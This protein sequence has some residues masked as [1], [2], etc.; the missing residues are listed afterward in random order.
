MN[1]VDIGNKVF[2][3]LVAAHGENPAERIA[4]FQCIMS[5]QPWFLPSWTKDNPD[6]RLSISNEGIW[7]G[8]EDAVIDELNL[9]IRA[10]GQDKLEKE[11][12]DYI[13]KERVERE[14]AELMLKD[15][16]IYNFWENNKDS[17]NIEIIW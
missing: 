3:R 7:F 12:A 14:K 2:D 9:Q 8:L 13:K 1:L 11:Q 17:T 15:G 10:I 16:A 5:N 4:F 6:A